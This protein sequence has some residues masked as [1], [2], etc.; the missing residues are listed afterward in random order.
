MSPRCCRIHLYGI[1]AA[2]G[3]AEVAES[4][5]PLT[6]PPRPVPRAARGLTAVLARAAQAGAGVTVNPDVLCSA[7]TCE[8]EQLEGYSRELIENPSAR[9][10][11]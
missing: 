4:P 3:G 5:V 1:K 8:I 11:E 10:R 2:F 7:G 9:L 6:C